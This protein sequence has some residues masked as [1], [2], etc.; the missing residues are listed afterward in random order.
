MLTYNV[1][2]IVVIENMATHIHYVVQQIVAKAE[3]RTTQP[4]P[5]KKKARRRRVLFAL[6]A[7]RAYTNP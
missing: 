3:S 2:A 7:R 4:P 6:R 5:F 1:N